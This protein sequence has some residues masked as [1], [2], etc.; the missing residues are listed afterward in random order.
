LYKLEVQ[1]WLRKQGKPIQIFS[2]FFKT[3]FLGK[4]NTLYEQTIKEH[5]I[6]ENNFKMSI[7]AGAH[8]DL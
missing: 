3:E 2:K 6:E 4:R 1:L 5:L 7:L 8:N